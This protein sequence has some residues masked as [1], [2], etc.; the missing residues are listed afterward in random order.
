MS[1]EQYESGLLPGA[2]P[3][4]DLV[5]DPDSMEYRERVDVVRRLAGRLQADGDRET[6]W[7]ARRITEWLSGPSDGDL[8]AVLGLRPPAGNHHTPPAILAQ[9]KRDIAML[10]LSIEAGGFRAALRVVQSGALPPQWSEL[11]EDPPKS[12]ASFTRARK[13]RVSLQHR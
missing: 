13:R 6:A 10:E 9:E 3:F 12:V 8:T 5:R 11:A 1:D 2:N 7:F 4:R